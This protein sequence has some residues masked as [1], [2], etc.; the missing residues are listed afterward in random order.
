MIF[1]VSDIILGFS[2]QRKYKRAESECLQLVLYVLANSQL[3]LTDNSLLTV[4]INVLYAGGCDQSVEQAAAGP[5]NQSTN[6]FI[7]NPAVGKARKK[8]NKVPNSPAREMY[9]EWIDVTT[10]SY[11]PSQMQFSCQV[12]SCMSALHIVTLLAYCKPCN[13]R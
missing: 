9:F 11:F 5:I 2:V 6:S 13:P 1:N 4:K 8:G 12:V 10:C 7:Y 3:S